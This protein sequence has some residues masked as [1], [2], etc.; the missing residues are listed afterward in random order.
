MRN[1]ELEV[2][3]GQIKKDKALM[4][5]LEKA[6]SYLIGQMQIPIYG[7]FEFFNFHDCLAA[8]VK[9]GFSTQ[10]RKDY[11]ERMNRIEDAYFTQTENHLRLIDKIKRGEEAYWKLD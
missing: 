2:H 1:Y 7:H 10:H 9:H 11:E 6:F 8:L 3:E 5:Y 4:C